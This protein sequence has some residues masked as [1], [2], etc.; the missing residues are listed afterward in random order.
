MS[1]WVN[2]IWQQWAAVLKENQ[3]ESK[4]LEVLYYSFCT[5]NLDSCPCSFRTN[6]HNDV[7]ASVDLE[8]S[9]PHVT[10]N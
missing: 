5:E 10:V 2:L 6:S 9:I 8:W 1:N 3:E 7:C 4:D